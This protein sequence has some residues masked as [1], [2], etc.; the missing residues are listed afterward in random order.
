MA[1]YETFE[2]S[3][4]YGEEKKE[5]AEKMAK[6]EADKESGA[7]GSEDAVPRQ[8]A[9]C[10]TD[11]SEHTRLLDNTDMIS[12]EEYA[13]EITH[14]A[15]SPL[16]CQIDSDNT[17][18]AYHRQLADINTDNEGASIN[19]NSSNCSS[20]TVALL[21]ELGAAGSSSDNCCCQCEVTVGVCQAC[22]Q[23]QCHQVADTDLLS[24]PHT[25]ISSGT[26][27][28]LTHINSLDQ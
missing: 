7:P 24:Q 22:S 20:Q 12:L 3:F 10:G 5:H 21:S 6:E 16:A 18:A 8:A 1:I 9:D 13:V 19:L 4:C 23:S 28:E 15:S 2:Y 26:A 11:V 14:R 27:R 25:G 17:H